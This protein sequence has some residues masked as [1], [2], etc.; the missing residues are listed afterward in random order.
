MTRP[1]TN[2]SSG[3]FNY[4]YNERCFDIFNRKTKY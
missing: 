2:S 1:V 4:R 3:S